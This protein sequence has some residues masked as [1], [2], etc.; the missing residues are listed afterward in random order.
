MTIRH[1][2]YFSIILGYYDKNISTFYNIYYSMYYLL[3]TLACTEYFKS[4]EWHSNGYGP[5]LT[6]LGSIFRLKI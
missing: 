3:Y 6:Q 1:Y 5:K 2:F 4:F